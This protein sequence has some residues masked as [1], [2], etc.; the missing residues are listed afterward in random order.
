MTN[1]GNIIGQAQLYYMCIHVQ[2]TFLPWRQQ[3]WGAIIS[4]LNIIGIIPKANVTFYA[5]YIIPKANVT[6]CAICTNE[7][8][9]VVFSH[10]HSS[11]VVSLFQTRHVNS[12]RLSRGNHSVKGFVKQLYGVVEERWQIVSS[13]PYITTRPPGRLR[14]TRPNLNQ[15]KFMLCTDES[16]ESRIQAKGRFIWPKRSFMVM[17]KYHLDSH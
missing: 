4:R 10:L 3:F 13:K 8:Y 15:T 16:M 14:K 11:K 5:I 2:S 9:R 12:P 17:G 6:F 1:H 7:S